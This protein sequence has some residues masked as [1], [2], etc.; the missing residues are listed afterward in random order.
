MKLQLQRCH[1]T[2]EQRCCCPKGTGE[3]EKQ[4]KY[5]DTISR[6]THRQ[7]LSEGPL[8]KIPNDGSGSRCSGPQGSQG[9]RLFTQNQALVPSNPEGRGLWV[10]LVMRSV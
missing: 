3:V 2:N 4:V 10:D 5:K 9:P 7:K 6:K 8:R 1:G